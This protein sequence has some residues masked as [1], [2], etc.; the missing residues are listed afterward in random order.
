MV[1]L[2]VVLSSQ[3]CIYV[4]SNYTEFR[5]FFFTF[6]HL[7]Y[8][9]NQSVCLL[10]AP[11]RETLIKPV[12]ASINLLLNVHSLETI[13]TEA[14]QVEAEP[15]KLI[16]ADEPNEKKCDETNIQKMVSD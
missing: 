5:W 7:D 11:S 12:L 15:C 8:C 13:V 14:E 10:S 6:S 2:L 16:Q 4:P 1:H 9:R 3:L